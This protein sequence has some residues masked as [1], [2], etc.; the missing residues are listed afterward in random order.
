MIR[1][2]TRCTL[3][4]YATLFR[5]NTAGVTIFDGAVGGTTALTS[6]TTDAAGSTDL[7]GGPGTTTR[8]QKIRR[9]AGRGRGE[10]SAAAGAF[11]KKKGRKG[12]GARNLGVKTA[13]GAI[14]QG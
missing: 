12:E 3:F 6:L 5:S 14:R 7:N 2:P 9:A 4:P 8:N 13:G 10:I 11:K 1:H